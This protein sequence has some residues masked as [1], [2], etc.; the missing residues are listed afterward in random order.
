MPGMG[1]GYSAAKA[2][3]GGFGGLDLSGLPGLGGGGG[4]GI[5]GGGGTIEA[6]THKL[7]NTS[8]ADVATALEKALTKA[9][10]LKVIPEPNSNTIIIVADPAT[11]KDALK[12]IEQLDASS[13]SGG[14]GGGSASRPPTGTGSSAGSGGGRPPAGGGSGSSSGGRPV[15]PMG[16]PPGGMMPPGGGGLFDPRGSG[17]TLGP[18]RR[19]TNC[20][21]P[22]ER[23]GAGHGFVLSAASSPTPISRPSRGRIN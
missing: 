3:A 14:G 1:G 22:E 8:A 18:A 12:L 16:G 13:G 4:R 11:L 21:E 10:T 2:G 20:R 23:D 5:L 7:K 6:M 15:G 19:R 17:S 9:K